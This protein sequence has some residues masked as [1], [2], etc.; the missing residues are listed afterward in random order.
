MIIAF[1]LLA[2]IC[3]VCLVHVLTML[4]RERPG[5]LKRST[6]TDGEVQ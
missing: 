6:W 5:S 3:V 1:A 2:L 4:T